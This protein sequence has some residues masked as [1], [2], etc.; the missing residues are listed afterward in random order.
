MVYPVLSI[1]KKDVQVPKLVLAPTAVSAG[2]GPPP[3]VRK[4]GIPNSR[5]ALT[6]VVSLLSDHGIVPCC[7][8][9]FTFL[10]SECDKV[11][12]DTIQ[13]QDK[14]VQQDKIEFVKKDIQVG[15]WAE[16]AGRSAKLQVQDLP[17]IR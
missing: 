4:H 1:E 7:C 2:L 11:Q 16:S 6:F 14:K 9:P 10:L 12:V 15:R 17:L 13:F 8:S 5:A 3:P